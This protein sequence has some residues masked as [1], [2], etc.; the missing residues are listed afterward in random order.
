MLERL[1]EADAF[2]SMARDGR[3]ALWA[4]RE[5]ADTVLPLFAAADGDGPPQPKVVE[6]HAA[7]AAMRKGHEVVE[8]YRK[9]GLT[10][11]QHPVAFLRS[12]L[13][14]RGMIECADLRSARDGRR[15]VVPGIVL[16]RQKPGSAKGVM[17]ITIEDEIGVANLV[18][19]ADRFEKQRRL[20]LLAGTIPCHGRI[21]REG[22]VIHVVTDH[23][24]DFSD[25]LRSVGNFDEP[26]LVDYGRGDDATHPGTRDPR[27]GPAAGPGGQPARATFLFP[28]LIVVR[29]S[30]CHFETSGKA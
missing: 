26:F 10:L 30:K 13:G 20:V 21:Q 23:L 14:S 3:Q 24:E 28:I 2:Q 27:D 12:T 18:L 11:G 17:F 6:P 15:V 9:V 8:D 29:A 16:V 1:A 22:D 19:W 4:V 5:Q 7:L 25:L